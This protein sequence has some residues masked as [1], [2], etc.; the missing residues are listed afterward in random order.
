MRDARDVYVE[1]LVPRTIIQAVRRWRAL[2]ARED[3]DRTSGALRRWQRG[4]LVPK[5]GRLELDRQSTVAG[6]HVV[7]MT[8]H[9]CR[10]LDERQTIEP[11]SALDHLEQPP[12]GAAE[13]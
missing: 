13:E 2:H 12:T 1:R 8:E 11:S 9:A 10:P 3:L 7:A 6:G 5:R 4:A